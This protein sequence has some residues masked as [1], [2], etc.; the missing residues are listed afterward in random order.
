[1]RYQCAKCKKELELKDYGGYVVDE[2]KNLC[3]ECWGGYIIIKHRHNRELTR[4]WGE[5]GNRVKA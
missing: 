1:M 3:P 5:N 2:L 4:W